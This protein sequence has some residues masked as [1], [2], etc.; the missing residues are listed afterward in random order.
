MRRIRSLFSFDDAADAADPAVH[1]VSLML[2]A[3]QHARLSE[4]ATRL[5]VSVEDALRALI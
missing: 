4:R 5:G 3:E 2:S 1:E